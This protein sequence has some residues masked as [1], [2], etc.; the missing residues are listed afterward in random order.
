MVDL[1]RL[2]QQQAAEIC[3]VTSRTLRDWADAP[4]NRD[5]SYH[6]RELVAWL[7]ARAAGSGDFDNQRERLA[8]AQAE[9]V[10][11]DNAVRKGWLADLKVVTKFWAD[12]LANM[13]ARLLNLGPKLGP[14]LVNIGDPHVIAAAIRAEVYAA[15][16]ELAEYEPR[17]DG[18]TE[19]VAGSADGAEAAADPDGK[20]VVRPR[21][22]TQQRK[23]R[24]ARALAD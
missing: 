11:H 15:L 19:A 1:S 17:P 22:A 10:E 20:R 23:Q 3:G 14:Q 4:R 5:G 9:K 13:R 8:A 24:R 2:T 7:V 12:C 16:A 21:K 18:G 6:A